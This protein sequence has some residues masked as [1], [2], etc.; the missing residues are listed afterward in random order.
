MVRITSYSE[1]QKEQ[2]QR[3]RGPLFIRCR[4]AEGAGELVP[5]EVLGITHDLTLSVL[6]LWCCSTPKGF[7]SLPFEEGQDLPLLTRGP[8]PPR[9]S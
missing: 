9:T 4:L 7:L 5:H 1:L 2:A 6:S 3:H 8:M